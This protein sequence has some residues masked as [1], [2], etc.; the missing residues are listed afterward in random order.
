[1]GIPDSH[2]PQ[3]STLFKFSNNGSLFGGTIDVGGMSNDNI[4]KV[5]GALDTLV[6]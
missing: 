5:N 2:E 3:G 1:L 4:D 6:Q